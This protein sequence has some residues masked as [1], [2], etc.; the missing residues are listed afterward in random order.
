[1][2]TPTVIR[3]PRMHGRPPI[4]SGSNVIRSKL[5]LLTTD[6]QTLVVAPSIATPP[7]P[8]LHPQRLRQFVVI[9]LWADGR[10]VHLVAPEETLGD[11]AHLVGGD[12]FDLRNNGID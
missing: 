10:D 5:A 8:L 6:P 11:G 9:Q 2:T 4:T 7:T 3:I 12:R 1:M